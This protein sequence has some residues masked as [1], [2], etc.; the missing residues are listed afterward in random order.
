MDGGEALPGVHLRAPLTDDAP[1]LAR[2]AAELFIQTWR[3][4]VDAGTLADYVS[5]AFSETRIRADLAADASA[6]RVASTFDGLCGYVRWHWRGP[7]PEGV[8]ESAACLDRIYVAPNFQG[9][10]VAD[11]LVGLCLDDLTRRGFTNVYLAHFPPNVRAGRYYARRGFVDVG[12][13]D[14]SLGPASY[15]VRVLLKNLRVD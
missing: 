10:G 2:L 13:F 14:Y 15:P 1:A 4:N 8:P 5:H 9:K 7:R 3:E 12:G 11:A 6:W